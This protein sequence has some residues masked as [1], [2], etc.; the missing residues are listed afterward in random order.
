MPGTLDE[1]F[2]CNGITM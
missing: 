2:F 1:K